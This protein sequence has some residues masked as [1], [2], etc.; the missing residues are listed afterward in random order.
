MKV[1]HVITG[2][3]VG[4]AETALCRLLESLP[5]PEF[6]HAVVA[7]GSEGMLSARVREARW[8]LIHLNMT[9]SLPNPLSLVRLRRLLRAERPDVVHSWMYHANLAVTMM[10]AGVSMPVLWS[11]RQSLYDFQKEKSLTRMVI[12]AGAWLSRRPRGILYNS[13]VSARQHEAFGYHDGKTLVIPNGFDTIA[14]CPNPP[15][16]SRLRMELG[17]SPGSFVI[18]LLARLHPIK[19]HET[20]LRAAALFVR[21]NPHGV[22]VLAGEG[23]D[24]KNAA[25]T[26]RIWALGLA[27]QVRLCGRRL[28][29]AAIYAALDIAS[30]SSRGEGFP[31]A[32]GEAMACGIPCVATD[33]GDVRDIVGNTGVVVPPKNPDAL[34]AGWVKISQMTEAARRALGGKARQRIV[35]RY[36]LAAM[37]RQYAELYQ[38][39]GQS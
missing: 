30:L 34:C 15:H 16:R 4:G 35:E 17:F 24:A 31:N 5:S 25:L 39:V 28:D 21:E 33:V 22:F 7:L 9:S 3:D 19:D 18:G 37:V 38:Q 26:E 13:R 12:R 10:A 20:F 8:R 11:I 32:I 14:F 27:D 6:E 29:V 1:L 36:A 23:I 2:L